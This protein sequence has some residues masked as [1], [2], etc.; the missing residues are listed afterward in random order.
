MMLGVA[1]GSQLL[2]GGFMMKM[3]VMGASVAGSLLLK[4]KSSKNPNKLNDLRVSSS[5]FGRGIPL[6]YGTMRVTGNMF[7]ATDFREDHYYMTNKGKRVE[8]KKG[9]KKE[10]KGKAQEVYDYYANFAMGLAMGPVDSLIRVWADNNLIYDKLNRQDPDDP[11]VEIGFTQQQ[12]R[13]KSGPQSTAGKGKGRQGAS[14]RFL[15]RFYKGNE[16]Q[17]PDSFMKAKTG[18]SKSPGYRGLCYLFFEDFALKDFGNRTPTITAEISVREQRRPAVEWCENLEPKTGFSNKVS[19][20]AHYDPY[21][22]K[23]YHAAYGPIKQAD[24][25]ILNN[26]SMIRCFDIQTMKEERRI[27][28]TDIHGSWMGMSHLGDFVWNMATQNASPIGFRDPD[29]MA[30]KA[31]WGGSGILVSDPYQ[32][33]WI[34]TFGVPLIG[35]DA[36]LQ[37]VGWTAVDSWLGVHIFDDDYNLASY[38]DATE[39]ATVPRTGLKKKLEV[40]QPNAV[41]PSG[42]GAGAFAITKGLYSLTE[43]IYAFSP[44][45]D[46]LGLENAGM[47]LVFEWPTAEM[48]ANGAVP[49]GG[50]AFNGLQFGG[51]SWA[52]AV[53]GAKI[54]G[55]VSW[56]FGGNPDNVGTWLHAFDYQSGEMVWKKRISTDRVGPPEGFMSPNSS[57]T[58]QLSWFTNRTVWTV[59]W[60]QHI[61]S[62]I[63]VGS[64]PGDG[65]RVYM[66]SEAY[67]QYYL[68]N[69]DAILYFSQD[70]QINNGEG[71]WIITYLDRKVQGKVLVSDICRDVALRSRIPAN[72]IDT[73]GLTVDEEVTGYMVENPTAGRDVL[74][75]LSDVFQFDVVE[76]DNVLKFISRGKEPVKIITQEDLGVVETDFGGENEY[77]TETRQQEIELPERCVV[78]FVDPLQKYETGNQSFKRPLRPI[79]VMG[80]QERLDVTLNM[81]MTPL[82]AKTLAQRIL[83]AAWGERTKHEYVL[84]PDYLMLDPSDVIEIHLDNGET[85]LDR[86]TDI[87][88]GAD[89][90]M[91]LNTVSQHA[92]HYSLTTSVGSPGGV[93]ELPWTPP[94][95]A[96]VGVFDVPYLWDIDAET[97][98][99]FYEFYWAALSS[100]LGYDGGTISSRRDDSD[101]AET[102]GFSKVDAIWGYCLTPVPPPPSGRTELTDTTTVLELAMGFDWNAGEEPRYTWESI[103]DAD[104]PNLNNMI[105]IGDEVILFKDVEVLANGH[106]KISHLIRGYR[107]SGV[108]AFNHDPG[109]YDWDVPKAYSKLEPWVLVTNTSVHDADHPIADLHVKHR[110]MIATGTWLPNWLAATNKITT[111]ATRKPFQVGDIERRQSGTDLIVSFS[112]ATRFGGDFKNL[113]ATVPVNE[114]Y[115][116]YEVYFL[117][118]A[119]DKSTWDPENTALYWNKTELTDTTTV[120]LNSATLTAAGKTNKSDIHLVIYQLSDQVGRGFPRWV[121]LPYSMFGL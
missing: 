95:N 102:E 31:V 5:T 52:G 85:L 98:P 38:I 97:N 118:A 61:V 4:D 109:T 1:F 22:N 37:P 89:L 21:R 34:P 96:K 68:A 119:Y 7:W 42:H 86:I 64:S 29:S 74:E 111:G 105:I 100:G 79:S 9:E 104:W 19:W 117:N 17:L 50:G 8:G 58:N 93:I 72:K 6:V 90:S 83:F 20:P 60:R 113:T 48:Q 114:Q 94:P 77:Y 87:E 30:I 26:R 24:G 10:K 11:I 84:P 55:V 121:S 46:R 63:Q 39:P 110:Y 47:E 15:F 35:T 3:A 12:G 25:S 115:E 82:R 108:A 75:E 54:L 27:D 16:E 71:N 78:E 112:R 28:I 57:T 107:G 81:A 45:P 101:Q 106:V 92:D 88:V 73:S 59:D 53:V 91:K 41:T 99:S 120:T 70:P 76:S 67:G 33:V 65:N 51:I 66:P 43:Q 18:A 44:D 103:E 80:S 56:W 36:T 116:K 32:A 49:G 69:K 40:G 62:S 23:L 13:G 2:G 14:G